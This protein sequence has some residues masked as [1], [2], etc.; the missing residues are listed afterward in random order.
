MAAGPRQGLIAC[1]L[2]GNSF[3]VI[4]WAH[5]RTHKMR[6]PEYRERYG[7]FNFYS[8]QSRQGIS[9]VRRAM[10]GRSRFPKFVARMPKDILQEL[11]RAARE[12]RSLDHNRW[13][14]RDYTFV[15]QAA[16]AFGS[17]FKAL[18]A[19]GVTDLARRRSWTK[20]SVR[21]SVHRRA[22]EGRALN[23]AAVRRDQRSLISAGS[24]LF[25]SW[26]AALAACGF[27]YRHG[28][29]KNQP[30][31]RSS[32]AAELRAWARKRGA[33]DL[34]IL[35]ATDS[36]LY[37]AIYKHYGS[38]RKAAAQLSLAVNW[39]QEQ[40]SAKKVLKEIRQRV[41]A[42]KPMAAARVISTYRPLYQAAT[43]YFG[44]WDLAVAAAGY[45]YDS[46]R[47]RRTWSKRMIGNALRAWVKANGPLSAQ[48]LGRSD[49]GLCCAT[50][51]YYGSL[52]QATQ[53]L[54]LPFKPLHRRW[55]KEIVLDEI[56][57]RI[58]RG[59]SVFSGTVHREDR[60]LH[61]AGLR[62]FSR[63]K[64]ALAACDHRG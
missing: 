28:I 46:W 31:D 49:C 21:D 32:I 7:P 40:W 15:S 57:A 13:R 64:K 55:N 56:R 19:A 47:C 17:W 42:G 58:K 14:Q 27:D 11:R 61:N 20:N 12:G 5:L 63:W 10:S 18:E 35:K 37:Q 25:G 33:L 52:A 60:N 16:A 36:A 24:R 1:R 59:E 54:H 29:R 50:I 38:V 62:Y 26:E 53:Q 44:R 9:D 4:N 30:R 23:W 3:K 2:C 45:S 41:A 6:N 51:K 48:A 39:R 8:P 22:K 43:R 34:P